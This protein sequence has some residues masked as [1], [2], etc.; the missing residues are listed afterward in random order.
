M[1]RY[2][3]IKVMVVLLL[4]L[5]QHKLYS[6][7]LQGIIYEQLD[8]NH[9]ESL[10]G[11][12]IYWLSTTVGTISDREGKFEIP[13]LKDKNLL[14]ISFIGYQNDTMEVDENDN[15][16]EI[17]LSQAKELNEVIITSTEAVYVSSRPILTQ[18]ITSEG[19]RKAAC[20][21]LSESFE[22]T[23]SVDVSYSDA[24]SGAKQIQMLGLAGIYTQIMLENTPYIRGLAAPFGLMYI[25]GSWMES[26]NISKGTS[27]VINGYESITGQIDVNYKKPETNKEKLF[28]N[29]YLNSMLKT[30]LN[31]NSR[32][33]VRKNS[34]TLLLFHFENQALKLDHNHDQFLDVPL[35]TQVNIMNR[36]DYA[37]PKKMEGRTMISYLYETR[38]GGQYSF[39]KTKDYLTENVYGTGISTHRFNVISKNGLLL[40]GEHESL[41]SIVSFTYHDYD[42]FYGIKTLHSKQLS[43][44]LNLFYENFMDKKDQHKIDIGM[45]YQFDGYHE[46]YNDSLQLRLESVPGLFTQYSF[47]LD[48]KFV[49]IAGLRGDIH[50]QYGLFLTPRF[51]IKWQF[52]ESTSFRA[53]AGKGYRAPNVYIEN[54]NILNSSRTLVFEEKIQAEE[55]WNVGASITHSVKAKGKESTFILDYFY[56][57]FTNQTIINLD[58]DPHYAYFYNSN[59]KKS[60]AHSA[61]IEMMVYPYKGFEIIAAYRFNHVMQEIDGKMLE[62][63]LHSKHKALLNVGYATKFEKWKFNITGQFHGAQRLPST[64]GN[65]EI[66]QRGDYSPHFF[67]FNAQLTKKFKYIDIYIGGENLSNYKQLNP[68]IAAE[69]P[70]GKYFDSS[71]IWG[72]MDGIMIYGGIRLTLK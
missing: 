51:H 1:N 34:S 65:P 18:S 37:I 72:P 4:L 57:D 38:Q 21:N 28:V 14:V 36:W 40:P 67:T 2:C 61:Q 48:D 23:I 60:F 56:T 19:L 63:S 9:K 44:Y 20:C 45:S 52:I 54:T 62:K 43:T 30:E 35:N 31:I 59:G 39:D 6:Q 17:T 71:I 25:P 7:T 3:N 26:I 49:A 5:L 24:V 64:A 47:I 22:S 50:N 12:T 33:A 10:T 8:D 16:I 11:A 70:F 27:S 29:A 32:H 15:N 58:R 53:S 55:A 42:A 41:A 46:T 13:R 69:D 66:Y 68:I